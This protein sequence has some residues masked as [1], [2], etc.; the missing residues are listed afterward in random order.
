MKDKKEKGLALGYYAS[1]LIGGITEP[2]LYGIGIKYKRP[3]IG[4]LAGGFVGGIYGGITHIG[5]YAFA[6]PGVLGIMAFANGG[7]ANTVNAAIACAIA[8]FVSAAVT[9]ILGGFDENEQKL[10][11]TKARKTR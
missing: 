2:T 7:L 6:S 3:F 1:C 11:L 9:F 4:M 10:K 5:C 8:M